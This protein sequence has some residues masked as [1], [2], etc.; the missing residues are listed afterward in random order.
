[1]KKI[2]IKHKGKI[3]YALVD[4]E[5]YYKLSKI[6]WHLNN[7]YPCKTLFRDKNNK[8]QVLCM[9]SFI[10]NTYGRP[11]DGNLETDH[12]NRNR[13]DNRK[14]NLRKCNRSQNTMNKPKTHGKGKYKGVCKTHNRWQASICGKYI[15]S[16]R[17]P[18]DAAK[19]YDNKAKELFGEFAFTNFNQSKKVCLY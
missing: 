18:E 13:L 5:D 8:Y 2:P 17:S 9:H 14:C 19:A 12:I 10:K 6:K 1:M 11:I 16:Y 15:G 7:G 3:Y 4:D